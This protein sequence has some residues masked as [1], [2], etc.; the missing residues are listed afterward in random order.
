MV[1][2]E[3]AFKTVYPRELFEADFLDETVASQYR[4]EQRTQGLFQLFTG[5]SIAI[6]ILGLIGLLS[7]LIESKT[8]EVG[9]RKVLGASMGDLSFLLSREFLKL[10]GVAFLIAAPVAGLLMYRWLQDFAYRASLS[11][12]MFAGGLGITFLVTALAISFQTVRAALM[13]PVRALRSE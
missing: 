7:F 1:A 4:E 10:M 9:I 8:R 6:N 13:N 3:K 5:L 2:I 11:W 12:W